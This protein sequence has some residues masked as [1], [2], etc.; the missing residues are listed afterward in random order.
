MKHAI[1][2]GGHA[3]RG[4]GHV[5]PGGGHVIRL[6]D[7]V[8]AEL[9][10]DLDYSTPVTGHDF[11]SEFATDEWFLQE[12]SG[13]YANNV[14]SETLAN[15]GGL[16]GQSA[17]GLYNGTDHISRNA[18]E[19]IANTNQLLSSGTTALDSAG[20]D[21]CVR[22]VFRAK[23]P[24]A[25]LDFFAAKQKATSPFQGWEIRYNAGLIQSRLYDDTAT[26]FLS[27][28][29]SAAPMGDG[30][31]HY[32]TIFYDATAETFDSKWDKGTGTQVDTSTRSSTF[33]QAIGA[34]VG[35]NR[36]VISE[37]MQVAYFGGCVGANAQAM[38]DATEAE[39]ILPGEDPAND[40]SALTPLTTIDRASLLSRQVAAAAVCHFADDRLPI[41][42]NATFTSGFGLRCNSAQENVIAYSEA[43]A[44]NWTLTNTTGTDNFADSPDGFRSAT[45]ITA[46][47]NDGTARRD[48]SATVASSKYTGSFWIKRKGVSDVDGKI[49][50]QDANAGTSTELAFTATDTWEPL[51]VSHTMGG[52][53]ALGR[54]WVHIDTSGESILISMCQGNLGTGRGSYIR[55]SGAAASL[56]KSDFRANGAYVN[57]P[58]GE[59][60]A[61]AVPMLLNG[62]TKYIYDHD[63]AFADQRQQWLA[64]NFKL[65]SAI[66]G[67]ASGEDTISEIVTVQG[68]GS[69]L[70]TRYLWDAQDSSLG[71]ES[72]HVNNGVT[73][74]GGALP[75]EFAHVGT[76]GIAVGQTYNQ[77]SQFDGDIQSI[78][79]YNAQNGA[80]P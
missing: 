66:R 73:K 2:G 3:I 69:L 15:T 59:L 11:S 31:W 67:G 80:L 46:T 47:S 61:V 16:Q 36:G 26:S 77:L 25:S 10:A 22:I 30:A 62:S 52:V 71:F 42:H 64:T 76:T 1:D 13:A 49:R 51:E 50:V 21:L 45:E 60:A 37:D 43:I 12:T 41:G 24:F 29:S 72:V 4:G 54:L 35:G 58:K 38:Y 44:A 33:T 27:T 28:I 78:R 75:Y 32:L 7:E 68:V 63:D 34:A 48:F 55:T 65:N 14:G 19:A 53:G 70:T 8:P 40:N 20:Q 39:C 5:L 9:L 79:S 57:V 6:R 17:M 23:N 56:V 18:W 74:N